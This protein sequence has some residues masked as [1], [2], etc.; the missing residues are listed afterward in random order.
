MS[1]AYLIDGYNLIHAMGALPARIGPG[2]L[3]KARLRLLGLL[4]ACFGSAA[5]AVTVAFDASGAPPG[6]TPEHDYHGLRIRF[7]V[8]GQQADDLIEDL[9]Q[10]APAP[11]QLVVV[12]DDHRLRQAARRRHAQAMKCT[13]FLDLLDR[14]R[15]RQIPRTAPAEKRETTGSDETRRWLEEFG[16]LDQDLRDIDF[17]F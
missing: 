15:R 13:A 5:P 1:V 10:H 3:E 8:G 9:I 11:K 12:S 14:L 7:A 17:P 6:C 2:G 4:H 16:H